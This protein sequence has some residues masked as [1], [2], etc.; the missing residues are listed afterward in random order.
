LGP[1]WR[2]RAK[3]RKRNKQYGWVDGPRIVAAGGVGIT[4]GH[5]DISGVKPDLLGMSEQIGTIKGGKYADFIATEGS[6]LENIEELLDVDFV[7]KGGKV[8]VQ[9]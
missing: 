9:K 4:C 8:F 5:A 3:Q 7:M 2:C 1:Y 6:P